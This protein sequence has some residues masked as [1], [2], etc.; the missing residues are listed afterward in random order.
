MLG[1]VPIMSPVQIFLSNWPD[2][3]D[4]QD[5]KTQNGGKCKR[6]TYLTFVDEDDNLVLEKCGKLK[7]GIG[8]GDEFLMNSTTSGATDRVRG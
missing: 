4:F 7:R 6:R 2:R 3:Q 8:I 5:T 1:F